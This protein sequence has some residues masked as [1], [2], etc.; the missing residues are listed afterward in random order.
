MT[1]FANRILSA[2]SPSSGGPALRGGRQGAG[3][4]PV[5]VEAPPQPVPLTA[6]AGSGARV[7]HHDGLAVGATH[8][9]TGT[10][11]PEP[12]PSP[13]PVATAKP[14]R[15]FSRFLGLNVGK[16]IRRLL[17][18]AS[19]LTSEE[20][21]QIRA[22][23]VEWKRLADI[24][25]HYTIPKAK[26]A[27]QA[28]RIRQLNEVPTGPGAQIN[29][30]TERDYLVSYQNRREAI[31]QARAV[32]STK[33]AALVRPALVAWIDGAAKRCEDLEAKEKAA[34][35]EHEVPFVESGILIHARGAVAKAEDHLKQL[36]LFGKFG[37]PIKD[38]AEFV[39]DL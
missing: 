13:T 5:P 4:S 34:A 24:E 3:L 8:E 16:K 14:K 28:E 20:Q 21:E 22:L 6:S 26:E 35:V 2:L 36:D 1:N 7:E 31:R 10:A 32:V 29:Q 17:T 19:A 11:R 12:A 37:Y 27:Y 9:S 18:G 39:A 23:D 15:D 30:F 33:A 25:S 38:I